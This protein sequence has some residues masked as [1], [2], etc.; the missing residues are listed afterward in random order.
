M[1][2]MTLLFHLRAVL[3]GCQSKNTPLGK[4]SFFCEDHARI[5]DEL[6]LLVAEPSEISAVC[7]V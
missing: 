3:S 6:N 7:G 2:P 1:L 4:D 5:I